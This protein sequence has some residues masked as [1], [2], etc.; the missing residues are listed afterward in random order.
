MYYS[1]AFELANVESFV[2]LREGILGFCTEAVNFYSALYQV[3]EGKTGKSADRKRIKTAAKI[4]KEMLRN[5]MYRN[6]V[7]LWHTY[8]QV[9]TLK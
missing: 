1:S 3:T 5:D 7:R 6:S 2:D 4:A 8:A 9:C